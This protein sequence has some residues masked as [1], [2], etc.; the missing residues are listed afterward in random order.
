MGS[1]LP[2][3]S[4]PA[5]WCSHLHASAPFSASRLFD[6]RR[7]LLERLLLGRTP[8]ERPAAALGRLLGFL[9]QPALARSIASKY[10]STSFRPACC[11]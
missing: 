11:P 10:C 4:S 3:M 1:E 9:R 6:N 7:K 8:V 2:L 5:C